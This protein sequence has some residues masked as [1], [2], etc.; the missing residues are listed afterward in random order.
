MIDGGFEGQHRLFEGQHKLSNIWCASSDT[1]IMSAI[2][3]KSEFL[4]VLL[5]E[6]QL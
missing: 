5:E 4:N 6:I 3:T 2:M 1:N